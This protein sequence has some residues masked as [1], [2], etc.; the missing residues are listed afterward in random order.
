MPRQNT[1]MLP[2][3]AI[4]NDGDFAARRYAAALGVGTHQVVQ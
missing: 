1:A 2:E 3:R 4:D